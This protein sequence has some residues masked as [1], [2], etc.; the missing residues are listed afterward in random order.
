MISPSLNSEFIHS[1]TIFIYKSI[2]ALM[3]VASS[4]DLSLFQK[5]REN[6]NS[7]ICTTFFD[8]YT[9]R[10]ATQLDKKKDDNNK[11]GKNDKEK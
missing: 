11:V 9:Y 3:P 6:A 2:I 7:N 8:A 4:F 10:Q 5:F 1:E